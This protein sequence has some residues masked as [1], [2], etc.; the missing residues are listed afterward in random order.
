MTSALHERRAPVRKQREIAVPEGY[1]LRG[2]GVY[3]RLSDR[4]RAQNDDDRWTRICGPVYVEALARNQQKEAWGRVV[5]W[6]DQ[7]GRDHRRSIPAE[8]FHEHGNGLAQEL[9][10]EGLEI[11]PGK[12]RE[13]MVYLGRY[14]PTART[15][16]ADSLGWMDTTD[17]RLVFVLP[18]RVIAS[19]TPEEIVFQPERWSP[20]VKSIA[21]NGSLQDWRDSVAS[22]AMDSPMLVFAICA[23]LAGPLV[24]PGNLD[25]GGFHVYGT[26]SRG[27]TTWLQCAASVWGCAADPGQAGPLAMLRRWTVTAN[28]A[29]GLAAAHN[30]LILPLDEIGSCPSKDFGG[31][32]YLLAGS[33]G[34][35][36]MDQSRNLKG[37][38]SWRTMLLS[39]GEISARQ[40][41]EESLR[42]GNSRGPGQ[43]HGGQ[44][45]RLID[46]PG[47]EHII[48]ASAG[49][50]AAV[51]ADA[52]KAAC[53]TAYG[54]AG[55]AFVQGLV[56]RY[57]DYA[58]LRGDL[59]IVRGLLETELSPENASA[60]VARASKRFAFVAAAGILASRL[61]VVMWSE[62]HAVD[63]VRAVQKL[64]L[65]DS[66]TLTDT[67][68]GV[69]AVREFCL[70]HSS[71]FRDASDPLEKVVN[72]AGYRR[73]GS[74]MF[75]SDGF[76]E[77][78]DGLDPKSVAR[79]LRKRQLLECN[80]G[81]RLNKKVTIAGLS[82]ALRLYVVDEGIVEH[83]TAY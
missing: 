12:E 40:K 33:L 72:L 11:V 78:C 58:A 74:F 8:R 81:A 63:A 28:G 39:T 53:G 68:R 7:D 49:Q 1:D 38:R 75:T 5:C 69:I 2:N 16:S 45:V 9:A 6:R 14:N 82:S 18:S 64:W 46:I 80:E 21:S 55:P 10:S 48:V 32:I 83:G 59:G 47:G 67:E 56:D 30:D 26:S 57:A 3:C 13:V 23:G 24:K 4:N 60:E 19:D 44:L 77:A 22:K 25:S 35:A 76:M 70:R 73:S 42:V 52:L 29:E 66:S 41:I 43:A 17:S 62:D 34:K 51:I 65:R 54:T 71:R 31:L 36:A 50:Q 79:E 15:L 37:M 20:T 61:N 27:K